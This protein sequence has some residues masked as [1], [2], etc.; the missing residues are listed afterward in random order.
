MHHEGELCGTSDLRSLR[1]VNESRWRKSISRVQFPLTFSPVP[2]LPLAPMKVFPP[3]PRQPPGASVPSHTGTPSSVSPKKDGG[4]SQ[5]KDGITASDIRSH[6]EG[7]QTI[8]TTASRLFTLLGQQITT[9]SYAVPI[10]RGHEM[11]RRPTYLL[12]VSLTRFNS[13]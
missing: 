5:P 8:S 2:T 1:G 12:V 7:L 6:I 4:T 13:L 11:V 9:I 3:N 10:Q